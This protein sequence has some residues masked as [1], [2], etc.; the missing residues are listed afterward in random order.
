MWETIRAYLTF[1][2]K[3][4]YGVLFLLLLISA[5]FVFPFFFRRP[6]GSP[7]PFVDKKYIEGI[8]RFEQSENDSS[9]NAFTDN[10]YQS[11]VIE[12]GLK[13]KYIASSFSSKMF[14]FDPNTI[15]AADWKTLGLTDH[16]IQT[17]RH[18]ID[19]GGRFHQAT[20]LSK[21]YGLRDNDYN[22][23]LPYVRITKIAVPGANRG[24]Q[25]SKMVYPYF[26]ERYQ[27]IANHEHS[28]FTEK[29][30][31]PTDINTADS[32]DWS[33]LPGVGAKLASRIIHFRE[34]LGGFYQIDQVGETFGLSDSGFQKIKFCL[35]LNLVD[36]HQID[37]NNAS[38]ETL[39]SHPYIRWQMTK[40]IL[41]Y[42]LQHGGFKSVDELQQLAQ[43]DP[44]KYRKIRPYV[45]IKP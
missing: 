13:K 45:V 23:L 21:L 28:G 33:R 44:E 20:D 16:L 25:T 31:Q 43:M 6:V 39:S 34:K 38:E 18:F 30:F 42:R 22:R 12:D 10:R 3:E 4:R 26:N 2:R 27:S 14:Y 1:T 37:L 35:R 29:K 5:L 9:K 24:G 19:K 40:A 32:A 11:E 15:T 8:K 7:D 17:I 41:E 36:L